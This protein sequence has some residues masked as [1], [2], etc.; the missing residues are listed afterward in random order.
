[1][2]C[3][4]KR[5]RLSAFVDGELT[6][7]ERQTVARHI[8]GCA[9]CAAII[10][11]YRRI[12]LAVAS[13][14]VP[15]PSDMAQRIATRLEREGDRGGAV[16]TGRARR[17]MALAAAG[18]AVAVLSGLAGWQVGRSSADHD[19]LNRDAVA[20]HLRALVQ[21]TPIQVASADT[22]TVK[23]WF[24]GRL[25]FAPAV[26]DLSGE[27]FSLAGGRLDIVGERRVAAVV[28]KRRQHMIS[29]F[30]WPSSGHEQA[31]P[32]SSRHQGFNVITWSNQAMTYAAV[33]DLNAGELG[34]LQ[35]LY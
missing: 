33:S 20:A 34:Q 8:S 29:V 14:A 31:A 32:R 6:P 15:T 19:R 5:E 16:A 4:E 2:P 23:P 35:G 17:W 24:T 3:E 22:H 18:L 11:D 25:D 7:A 26:K 21:D 10:D 30:V 1:M 9:D 27:G 13:A 28:Y 12:G